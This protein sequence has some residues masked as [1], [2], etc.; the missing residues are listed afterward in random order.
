MTNQRIRYDI[1]AA[2]SGQQDVAA[3]SSQ[4]E[5]LA[6]TLEG[7]AKVQALEL[8]R[9][10][11]EL[12]NKQGAIDSFVALKREA[13]DAAAK[14]R[15]TQAAAQSLGQSIAQSGTPT[16]AQAG[17]LEKLRDAVRAAK[18]ELQDKTRALDASRNTLKNY[19]VSSDQVAAAERETRA[20]IAQA[21]Q[22]VGRIAPAYSAAGQAARESGQAQVQ[23]SRQA[24]NALN[25]LADSVKSVAGT[26]AA[27]FTAREIVQ[28]AAQMES[29]QA[30]LQA[31]TGDAGQ[32]ATQLDFVRRVASQAGVDVVSAGK[33]WLGL[34]AS[35]KGTA[36][37]GEPARRVFESVTVAMARAGR[38][39]ADTERAL[40][41]LSQMASK[42]TVAMEEL[43]GQLGESLPGALQAAANGLGITTQDLI[44][45]VE[46][47]QMAAADLFPALAKGLDDLYAGAPKAQTLSQ[48][49]TGI[50]NAFITMSAEVGKAGGLQAMKVLA[51]VAQATIAALGEVIIGLGQSFGS[52]AS[53][54]VNW[55][56]SQ[57]KDAF[58]DASDDMRRRMLAAAEDNTVLRIALGQ[59]AAA[60]Q[61]SADAQQA[62]AQAAGASGAAS[63]A[64]APSVAALGAA[65][66]KV[67]EEVEQQVKLSAKEVEAAKARGEAAIAQAKAAGD[68][69]AQRAAVAQAAQAEAQAMAELSQRRRTDVEVLRAELAA[70]EFV[71]AQAPK[72]D[73]AR[74]KE[75]AALK[76]L[77][78]ERQID[79]D[80]AAAQAAAAA[81]RARLQTEEVQLARANIETTDALAAARRSDTQAAI[82]SLQA[83]RELTR[84]GIELA[85]LV[86]NEDLARSLRVEQLR[87]EIELVKARATAAR[88]EAEGSIAVAQAKMAELE[89]GGQLTVAK[90]VEMEASIR[91]A[92]AK[93]QEAD[94]MYQATGALEKQMHQ[95]LSGEEAANKAAAASKKLGQSHRALASDL[96][97]STA[98][99]ERNNAAAARSAELAAAAERKR[100]NVDA[101]GFSLD[102]S[103]KTLA[104]GSD[105]G[106]LTG[107]RNFLKSAGLGDEQAAAIA[108]QFSDGRGNIPYIDNP[109]KKRYGQTGDTISQALLRAAERQMLA[110]PTPPAASGAPA[111]GKTVVVE[112]RTATGTERIATDE[113]GS[114]AL[115]R[116]LQ[117]HQLA[118]N[119]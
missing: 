63:A 27:G 43:R 99:Q 42:G 44:K 67:R 7:D 106:T 96:D 78:Q 45:L 50:R 95:L 30:G 24:Q 93:M 1:Q 76:N 84:Q 59:T 11:K 90:R 110:Q 8:S 23:A 97:E 29:L 61:A 20:A 62:A 77:I 25:G 37:E 64:A 5:S 89:A 79:A 68:E 41:A 72:I 32:A 81:D 26:L 101:E 107:I 105:L 10:L 73:E 117:R 4:I 58:A 87:I 118:A 51:E 88:V 65:Y 16:K 52:V 17:Q 6:N 34:A 39:S 70:K 13:A 31:V 56:F 92:R 94:A 57:L 2:V 55:D 86:G 112:L 12:G 111:A 48:E 104:A 54:I 21:R 47:G 33:A 71:L 66:A 102:R 28:A 49:L 38:S 60:A 3:L 113:A 82:A 100:L 46:T 22:E 53:S 116:V 35:V 36:L 18:T 9:A 75:I 69:T 15:D 98:A 14:L 19:G 115:L 40:L 85:N 91:L 108:L 119:A 80:K 83:Q 74:Q 114:A 103:G 109:G